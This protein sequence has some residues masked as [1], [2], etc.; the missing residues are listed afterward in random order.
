MDVTKEYLDKLT[1]NQLKKLHETATELDVA[2][3]IPEAQWPHVNAIQA[4]VAEKFKQK[5]FC[6]EQGAGW[7]KIDNAANL[8]KKRE[9]KNTRGQENSGWYV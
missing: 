3:G 9:Q 6:G 7:L 1:L 8:T 2:S 4:Y 5:Y